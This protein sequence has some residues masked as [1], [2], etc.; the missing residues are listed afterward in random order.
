MATVVKDIQR[1]A[2]AAKR[3]FL[4]TGNPDF[5]PYKGQFNSTALQVI[6]DEEFARFKPRKLSPI[7]ETVT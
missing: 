5:A 3:E 1:I 4:R 7:G 6:Y 2:R